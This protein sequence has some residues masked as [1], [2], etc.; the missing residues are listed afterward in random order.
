MA[1]DATAG[2]GHDTVFLAN[3]VGSQGHVWAFDIQPQAILATRERAQR[4]GLGDRISLIQADH[5]RLGS[6][7][8]DQVH[9]R[10]KAAMFNLGYLP[11]SNRDTVTR[12]EST[13]A[14]LESCISLLCPDGIISLIAYRGHAGGT[15]ECTAIRDW[16]KDGRQ[17]CWR[18]V[19]RGPSLGP[20]LFIVRRGKSWSRLQT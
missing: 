18:C 10:I 4:Q 9:G 19:D 2:N 20:V 7:L 17:I 1:V 8:P 11:G 6:H 14:A 16:L 5:R 12:P 3:Q 13:L 15:E